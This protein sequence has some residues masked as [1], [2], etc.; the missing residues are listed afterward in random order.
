MPQPVRRSSTNSLI[1][2]TERY[3]P[4]ALDSHKTHETHKI[5]LDARLRNPTARIA[6]LM[7]WNRFG[8]KRRSTLLCD[9]S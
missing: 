2:H 3:M 8:V 9:Q 1:L 6:L 7:Y 4:Q 5:A